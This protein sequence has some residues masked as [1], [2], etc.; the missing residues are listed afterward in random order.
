MV[1][2]EVENT[3]G[4]GG[5]EVVELYVT[6]LVATVPVPIR[7]LQGIKHLFLKPGERRR[8]SFTLAPRQLTLI[9]DEG[10]R[11]L[12][13]GEFRLSVGGKQPGFTGRTDAQTTG[14]VSASLVVAGKVTEIKESAAKER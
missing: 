2:A 7:S 8:F 3:G 14:V 10:R 6:D 12:E 13:P 11:V 1:S 9:D 5:D 4:R